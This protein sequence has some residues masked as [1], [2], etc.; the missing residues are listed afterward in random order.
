MAG[1]LGIKLASG[2][3]L[4]ALIWGEDR[5][6]RWDGA[7]FIAAKTITDANWTNGMV[8]VAEEKTADNTST[9]RYT[10]DF[11]T[12][13]T[14]PGEYEVEYYE[15][16]SPSPGDSRIGSQEILWDGN[17]VISIATF[18]QDLASLIG[19]IE[20]ILDPDDL[21]RALENITIPNKR[22]ILAPATER[23]D[24]SRVVL[25]PGEEP[26]SC[27]RVVVGPCQVAR[28]VTIIRENGCVRIIRR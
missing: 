21:E 18:G 11:P 8:S 4:K 3:T 1:E 5:S 25:A 9:G 7:S 17:R 16:A 28:G 14:T 24:T 19:D 23:Q 2:L 15:G 6:K 10:G 22:V 20:L 26:Q 27:S 13:I 12:D